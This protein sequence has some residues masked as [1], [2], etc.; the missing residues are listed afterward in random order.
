VAFASYTKKGLLRGREANSLTISVIIVS[1]NVKYFLEQ[2]LYSVNQ[3]IS[4]IEAEIFV[5]D[6]ASQDESMAYLRPRFPGVRFIANAENR[7]F[8]RANNQALALATGKYILFLNP[9]TIVAGDTLEKSIAFLASAKTPGAVGVRM[10]DGAGCYLPE[11][12]R[13]FPSLWTAFCKLSGMTALFPSSRLFARYYLGHLSALSNQEIDVVSGAFFL[14]EKKVLEQTGS[15]DDQFFMYAEDI[16]LSY[17]LQQSGYL[18]YFFAGTTIIHFK[19][20][21]TRKDLR[22][23][24]LF[25]RAMYQFIRKHAGSSWF[26]AFLIRIAIAVRSLPAVLRGLFPPSQE[27]LA[28][29]KRILV[30]GD[31][32]WANQLEGKL[33][34]KKEELVTRAEEANTVIFAEGPAC[35]FRQIVSDWEQGARPNLSR[36][37]S[38]SGSG[39][40]VGS[41]SSKQPGAV[42]PF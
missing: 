14:V 40:A 23:A 17:R 38:A 8:A 24:R 21:S 26:Y 2:F 1:Y 35:S 36:M 7:G 32:Q 25:Y 6:N 4:A 39:S 28:T 27:K 18:N 10:I 30:R 5:V 3:A 33:A 22:Y 13:G 19:G 34:A 42:I 31:T 15:F 41:P 20:E 37:I 11:S 9:D 16:D 12:K 29:A